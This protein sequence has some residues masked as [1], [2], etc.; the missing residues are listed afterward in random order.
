MPHR[1]VTR[2]LAPRTRRSVGQLHSR[3]PR[4]MSRAADTIGA[5]LTIDE[6]RVGARAV[7]SVIGE[8]DIS[9]AADLLAAIQTA[10]TRAFDIWVDLTDTTF[11][12]PSGLHAMAEARARLAEASRRL[13]L[14]CPEGPVLRVLTL[15]GLDRIFEIHASRSAANHV[16]TS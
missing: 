14:I 9:T 12:D 13:V 5:L 15:T 2:S 6:R 8:V 10:G 11:M 16:T 7:L 1:P 3:A 4:P